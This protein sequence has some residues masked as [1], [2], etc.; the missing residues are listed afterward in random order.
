MLLNG[1]CF[2][3]FW[4][5]PNDMLSV[6]ALE[7]QRQAFKSARARM[8]LGPC[9]SKKMN[10]H[11]RPVNFEQ[12][13]LPFPLRGRAANQVIQG[14]SAAGVYFSNQ[15]C[16][17]KEQTQQIPANLSQAAS[18]THQRISSILKPICRW[19]RLLNLVKSCFLHILHLP[20]AA[21]ICL[22]SVDGAGKS[23]IQKPHF[24]CWSPR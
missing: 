1:S 24:I 9:E 4:T 18:L 7:S 15:Q 12:F 14:K 11:R 5:V 22:G 20:V 23:P 19:L 8:S 16:I 17:C 3:G 2:S 6:D 13:G 10:W 21:G